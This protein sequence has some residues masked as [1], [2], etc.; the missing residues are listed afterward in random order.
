[1]SAT[2]IAYG[3]IRMEPVFMILGQSAATVAALAIDASSAVQDVPYPKL[4]E[5]LLADGQ[6]LT[7]T[8]PTR[9]AS[10]GGIDPGTLAGIVVDDDAA[11]LTGAWQESGAAAKFVANGYRHDGKSQ[12]GKA[13][14]RFE[15]KLPQPGRYEVRLAW[16]PNNNRCSKVTV[17]IEHAGGKQTVAV[18]QRKAPDGDNLFG[19]LGTFAFGATGAVTVSNREA[20]GYVVIDAAQWL[21]MKK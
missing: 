12:D 10:R 19:S 11:K 8:G 9:A 2:H 7:Y 21:P 16:P 18:D 4:R 14:A 6:I 17:E 15:A 13:S 1:M 3:S 20:D 5:R